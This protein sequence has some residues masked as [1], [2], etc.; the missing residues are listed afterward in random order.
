MHTHIINISLSCRRIPRT[1]VAYTSCLASSLDIFVGKTLV[2]NFSILFTRLSV[3]KK[4]YYNSSLFLNKS[5]NLINTNL[6]LNLEG[7]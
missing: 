1:E 7:T 4:P 6:F 5:I 2:F 3:N